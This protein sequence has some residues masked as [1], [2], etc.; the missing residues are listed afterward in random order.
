M[1]KIITTIIFIVL[2][3][4]F[5][6]YFQMRYFNILPTINIYPSNEVEVIKVKNLVDENN[7]YYLDL[8][9]KTDDTVVNAFQEIVEMDRDNLNNIALSP[10]LIFICLFLK[11]FINRARPKTVFT[12]LNAQFSKTANTPAYPSGHCMQ[13][14]YLAKQLSIK[15]PDKENELFKLAEDCALARVYAGLH[16]PSDNDFAKYISLNIL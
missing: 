5:K 11:T 8:F 4:Y 15:Y 10:H 12:K 1:N 13:A 14:Y 16:Y 2:V 3:L 6:G 7:K 9:K